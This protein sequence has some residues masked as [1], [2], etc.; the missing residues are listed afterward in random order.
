[1]TE[2]VLKTVE[3]QI[4]AIDQAAH[5][6]TVKTRDGQ[7]HE[8]IWTAAYNGKMEK[9][10]QWWFIKIS[11]EK[12]GEYWKVASV[13]FFKRPDD[14][15]QSQGGNKGGWQGKPRNDKAIMLQ[16]TMKVCA[17]VFCHCTNSL[18]QDFEGAMDAIK[19][20]AI[21]LTNEMMKEAGA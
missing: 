6:I 9:Q 2:E 13:D 11:A 18:S 7:A 14:W 21:S 4:I 5:K 3:G 1:M 8:M 12:S 16:S 20:K 19:A 15:P 17:E 10:K